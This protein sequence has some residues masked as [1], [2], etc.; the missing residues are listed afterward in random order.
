LEFDGHQFHVQSDELSI[1][2]GRAS[3]NRKAVHAAI[4]GGMHVPNGT[5]TAVAGN[6]RLGFIPGDE[7]RLTV[8]LE[9][10]SSE[11]RIRCA[12]GPSTTER[13]FHYGDLLPAFSGDAES[14]IADLSPAAPVDEVGD[15]AASGI[16][17]RFVLAMRDAPLP[18]TAPV[19]P[20]WH[21]AAVVLG[22][23]PNADALQRRLAAAGVTV[24]HL[25][26]RDELDAILEQ[27]ESICRNGPTPHLFITVGRDDAAAD[28]QDESAWARQRQTAVETPFFVCQKWLSLAAE[29][30]WLDRCTLTA[31][32]ALGGDFGFAH[33][34][35]AHGGALAGLLKA[36]FIE[37]TVMQGLSNLR[38]K[39]IDFPDDAAAEETAD[40]VM[41]ELASGNLDYEVAW[42]GARRSVPAAAAQSV[43]PARSS[44]IHRGATWVVTGGGRGL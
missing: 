25:S 11:L 42:N 28:V 27:L 26:P 2:L 14:L 32:T 7:D 15:D 9:P 5:A 1:Q 38:A 3:R 4:V 8:V 10:A 31:T 20:T 12:D 18:A 36:V 34:A 29:G 40:R 23:G 35:A 41:V 30:K 24:H 43:L 13:R 16:T 33:G 21:G 22:S 39:V 19:S 37:F 44:G 6:G 17:S